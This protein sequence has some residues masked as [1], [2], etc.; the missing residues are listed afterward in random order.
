MGSKSSPP[1]PPDYVGA[2]Q[3]QGAANVDTAIAQGVM[4]RPTTVN[5]YGRSTWIQTGTYMTPGGYNVPQWEQRTELTPLGQS[6]FNKQQR[7]T[8]QLYGIGEAGLGRVATTMGQQFSPTDIPDQQF[9]LER[10]A[11]PSMPDSPDRAQ[12]GVSAQAVQSAPRGGDFG[13]ARAG[14]GGFNPLYY[15]RGDVRSIQ[16]GPRGDAFGLA[17][18]STALPQLASSYDLTGVG[19]VNNA[20][21]AARAAQSGPAAP[22]LQQQLDTSRLAAMPVQAGMTAQ[23]AILSRLNP[24]LE[25]QRSQ[26]EQQLANQGI[27][28]GS[29]AYATAQTEQAQRENDLRTQA[30]LQGIQLD[31]AA[32]QQ[33]LGEA[34]ALGGFANQAALQQFGAGQQAAQFGNQAGQQDFANA[35][36]AQEAA[37][38]AQQ[39]A[40]AQRAQSGQFG[41]E[42]QL[43]SFGAQQQAQQARNQAI[44]QNFGQASSAADRALAAQQQDFAQSLAGQQFTRDSGMMGFQNALAVGDQTNRA[45]AQNFQQAL[46]SQQAQNEAAQQLFAQQLAAQAARNAAAGQNQ[47]QDLA[48][49]QAAAALQAQRFQQSQAAAAFLNAQRQSALQEQLALRNQPLNELNALLSSQQVVVPQFAGAPE[50]TIAPPPIFNATQAQGNAA[51]QAYQG[52]AAQNAQFTS[53]LFGL[54]GAALRSPGLFALCDRRLKTDIERIGTHQAT[55]L[56]VYSFRY[57]WGEPSVGFMADEVEA[58]LPEAV[59]EVDGV[60]AVNYGLVLNS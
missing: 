55:G 15:N 45:I 37:N 47:Q 58:V 29:E 50:T 4:N 59:I 33:G 49:L 38:R 48:Q 35:L 26:L 1:P 22:Q 30:A 12:A 34:Q 40:F 16:D 11:L 46:A 60:K 53:D 39:Q 28:R 52:Q 27:A 19:N 5:P 3:A 14:A 31:M 43:A 24:S 9:E 25:R 8:D 41:N 2:A 51:M 57:L 10:G 54:G 36:A 20:Q 23:D 18:Q 42:A 7:V 56:P 13:S 21:L 17:S 32:R 44:A 6:A